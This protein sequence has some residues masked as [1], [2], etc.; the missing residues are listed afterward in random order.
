MALRFGDKGKMTSLLVG[1]FVGGDAGRSIAAMAAARNTRGVL[2]KKASVGEWSSAKKT[3][4]RILGL[5]E[6]LEEVLAHRM[7]KKLKRPCVESRH[8]HR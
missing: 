2:L 6:V 4:A 3:Q 1:D 7:T 5:R 8:E